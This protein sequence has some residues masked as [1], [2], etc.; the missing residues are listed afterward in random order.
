MGEEIPVQ[1]ILI[2]AAAFLRTIDII[3]IKIIMEAPMAEADQ[4]AEAQMAAVEVVAEAIKE[5]AVPEFL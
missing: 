2:P 4:T 1:D 3:T 5:R